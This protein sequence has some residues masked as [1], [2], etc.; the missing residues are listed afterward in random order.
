MVAII[1]LDE[2]YQMLSNIIECD[3]AAVQVG[4][5]VEVAFRIASDEITLP[6]FRPATG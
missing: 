2:G 3:P 6:Y 5:R 4:M 1:D